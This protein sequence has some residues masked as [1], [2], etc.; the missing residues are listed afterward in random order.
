MINLKKIQKEIY[1]NKIA[2]G[3][4]IADINCEF[5]LIY[6]E[7]AEAFRAYRKKLPGLGEELADIAIYLLGLSQILGIDLEREI[8]KKI[9]KNKKRQY[10][11]KKGVLRRIKA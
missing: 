9:K 10:I 1:D 6:E 2:K 11:R 3:F 5:N 4:N 7:L 8:L